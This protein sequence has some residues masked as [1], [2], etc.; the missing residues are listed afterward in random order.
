MQHEKAYIKRFNTL[1]N[2]HI[3]LR[4]KRFLLSFADLGE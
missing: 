4:H 2:N 3:A 1:Y